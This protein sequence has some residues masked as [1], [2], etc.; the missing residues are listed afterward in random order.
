MR[1]ATM[2][3]AL[4]LMLMVG[5]QSCAVSFGGELGSDE[6]MAQGG[7]VG[8]L[9]ALLFMVGGAFALPFPL[10]SLIS[11]SGA[12]LFAVAAAATT[13]FSDL[14]FWAIAALVLAGMSFFGILEKRKKAQEQASRVQ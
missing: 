1:I 8:I 13:P 12:A 14:S 9:V 3:L 10:V 6:G 4:L 7:A 2:I 11:F 5:L